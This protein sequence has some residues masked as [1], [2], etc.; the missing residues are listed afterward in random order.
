MEHTPF[1]DFA[2]NFSS[3]AI[4]YAAASIACLEARE[5]AQRHASP[6]IHT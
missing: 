2:T 1:R 5:W 3:T 4:K 6:C